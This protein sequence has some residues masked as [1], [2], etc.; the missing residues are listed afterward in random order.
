MNAI[1]DFALDPLSHLCADLR[2]ET[3]VFTNGCFDI[4]HAG[5][6]TYLA[7]ARELGT[8]LVVG[9]NSDESVR[10]L[11]G[12]LRPIVPQA[13]RALILSHLRCVDAVV[14]F[15]EDTPLRLIQTL[16]PKVLVKGG[17]YTPDQIVG[18]DWV[19]RH[20]GKVLSLDFVDNR[21]TSDIVNKI[22]Q[23]YC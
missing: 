6:V 13:D 20:G 12:E 10:R 5:H 3:T 19:I 17:D 8:K 14:I 9:L 18:S 23:G 1:F 15:H 22:K 16:T 4:L 11:K 2:S 7:K 21:S